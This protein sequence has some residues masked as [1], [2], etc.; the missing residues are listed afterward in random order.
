MASRRTSRDRTTRALLAGGVAGPVA[1]TLAWGVAGATQDGYPVAHE[2]ISG[3][4][5]ADAH[6][7]AAMRAGFWALGAGLVAFAAGMRRALPDAGPVAPVLTAAAGLATVVAGSFHRDTMLL[8]PPGRPDD[9]RQSWRNDAHDR[10]AGVAFVSG[11]LTPLVLASHFRRDPGLAHLVAPS[12]AV[13]A[14]EA[15][16]LPVFAL[17]V[18][19]RGNGLL[20]RFLVTLPLV[21]TAGLALALRR[22]VGA[23]QATARGCR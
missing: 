3:L 23:G 14:V 8:N 22:R 20:Q 17:D 15:V 21:G 1:F 12:V 16:G 19:R 2:H 9:H 10:A 18:D 4:A 5:A 7:P 11:L 13:T 6:R